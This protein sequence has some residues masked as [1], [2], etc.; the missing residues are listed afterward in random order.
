MRM[1]YTDHIRVQEDKRVAEEI[2]VRVQEVADTETKPVLFIGIYANELNPS[3]LRGDYIGRTVFGWDR[4][5]GVHYARGSQRTC[6]FLNSLGMSFAAVSSEDVALAA[7]K[8]AFDA[9]AWPANGSVFDA[10]DCVVIKLCEDEWPEEVLDAWTV[11]ADLPEDMG[12]ADAKATIDSVETTDENLIIKGW[13]DLENNEKTTWRPHLYLTDLGSGACIEIAT[14]KAGRSNLK[15]DGETCMNNGFIGMAPLSELSD[16]LGRYS[17]MLAV[18]DTVSGDVGFCLP[19]ITAKTDVFTHK[20]GLPDRD[21]ETKIDLPV[22]SGF[23]YKGSLPDGQGSVVSD[24]TGGIFLYGPYTDTVTGTYDITLRYEVLSYADADQGTFDIAV[25]TERRAAKTFG[26]DETSVTIE[27][28]ELTSGHRF[29][30]R[31][32]A[33]EDMIVRVKSIEYERI[34]D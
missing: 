2:E 32:N 4:N 24:G 23:R 31:V 1:L 28:V 5:I 21:T 25:D 30:A 17:V 3:C 7:R 33:P 15:I 18:E 29:E 26:P 16:D 27:G 12:A 19:N 14:E 6:Q 10:G 20:A 8:L 34:K 11:E 9:P 13:L 22:Y